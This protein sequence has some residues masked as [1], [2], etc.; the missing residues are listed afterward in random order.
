MN[1]PIAILGA[2]PSGLTL[3]RLL[4][5]ANIPFK[6]FERDESRASAAAGGSGPLD[7]HADGGQIALREAGL[8]DHFRKMA[9]I[10][11]TNIIADMH[12]KV[13]LRTVEEGE[14]TDRPEIDR[15]DLRKMLLESV[16][17]ERVRWDCK[18]ERVQREDDGTM[19]IH[20]ANG[21]IEGG[22]RLVVGADGTWSKV[23]SLVSP[24]HLSSPTRISF[25]NG[26]GDHTCEAGVLW[27]HL[28]DNF[29]E[30]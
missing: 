14:E 15:K 3:A 26:A 12:G 6:V 16:E 10:D 2:G 7:I 17:E 22:F 18:V 28:P 24:Y 23:R 19:S 29:T 5:V 9:R 1:P 11:T 25:A 13:Y 21:K 8:I 20:F 27:F 4:Q 30:Q